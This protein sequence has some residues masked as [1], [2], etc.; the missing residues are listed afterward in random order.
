[1]E[2]TKKKLQ[3]TGKNYIAEESVIVGDV[4]MGEDS[5]VFYYAV[6]RGDNEPIVIGKRTNIQE[7]CVLHVGSKFPMK[8]GDDV[9]VGHGA[10]LHGCTIGNNVTIGMG[11]IVMNGAV[12]GDNCIIGAGSVITEGKIIPACSLAF[13][14]PVKIIRKLTHD[15]IERNQHSALHYIYSAAK[16]FGRNQIKNET[17]SY[18]NRK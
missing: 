18:T 8:I 12:I 5:S 13:G 2:D 4:S 7:N 16:L 1:M 10:I 6:I 15:E 3:S 14:S 11:S 17:N 9:T